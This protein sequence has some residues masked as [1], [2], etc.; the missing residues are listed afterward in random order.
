[1]EQNMR[2]GLIL[3]RLAILKIFFGFFMFS[4]ANRLR[5]IQLCLALLKYGFC[6]KSLLTN[7]LQN[8]YFRDVYLTGRL[9]YNDFGSSPIESSQRY[10]HLPFQGVRSRFHFV[11]QF[12]NLL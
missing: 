9:M 2:I 10:G 8:P 5:N 7:F 12:A 11:S 4:G 1:M 3:G 6:K